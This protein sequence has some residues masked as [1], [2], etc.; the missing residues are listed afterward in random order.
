M[1]RVSNGFMYISSETNYFQGILVEIQLKKRKSA[2]SRLNSSMP[3]HNNNA[4]VRTAQVG[5]KQ[6]EIT[7]TNYY[8]LVPLLFPIFITI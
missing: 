2:F 1:L 4:Y 3:P 6:S 7:T 5:S 8:I